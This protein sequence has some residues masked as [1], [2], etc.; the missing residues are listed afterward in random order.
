MKEA[1]LDRLSSRFVFVVGKGGVGKTTAA[2][3]VALASA[4]RGVATLL[5]STDPAH[6]L[7]DLF[8]LDASGGDELESPCTPA[9]HVQ[10]LDARAHVARWMDR[11]REPVRDLFD[12]GTYLEAEDV[13]PFLDLSLPG[14]DEV[15]GILHLADLVAAWP[16]RV[17]V[18]TAPTG[19]ALRLLDA[20]DVVDSWTHAFD[21]MAAKIHAVSTGLIGTSVRVAAEDLVDELATRVDAYRSRVLADA[22]VL[23]VE[24]GGSVV[25]AESRR[26]RTGLIERGFAN[27]VRIGI[28][29]PDDWGDA[30][31]EHMIPFRRDLVGCDGLRRWGEP[32]GDDVFPASASQAGAPVEPWI[33]AQPARLLFFTGKGGVG[34]STCAAAWALALVDRGPVTLVSVDP[35]G[36]LDDVLGGREV[37]GLRVRQ[38]DADQAFGDFKE[39]YR[40]SVADAFDRITGRGGAAL[41]RRVVESL[42]ELAPAGLDEIFAVSAL[43]DET[44]GDGVVIVDTAPTGHFLR[45]LTMPDTGLA[46]TRELMRVLLKYRAVLGLDAF[47]E[48]LLD[49]AKR[50]KRLSLALSDPSRAAAVI[51]RQPGPLVS[52]ESA[53]L[54]TSLEEAAV[55]IAAVIANREPAAEGPPVDSMAPGLPRI[56]APPLAEPPVGPDALRAF[57]ARW[58]VHT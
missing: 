29:G 51:V 14:I 26:L 17:V 43:L 57:R 9:L 49:F 20:D 34:K 58:R 11:A 53:R 38:V 6:S 4:D 28:E 8:G 23:V 36:S 5:L 46:W 10:E 31:P 19:H 1:L 47:A 54:A 25:R 12:R 42:L 32:D 41:D 44:D 16:E 40:E 37:P 55:S 27:V 24:R 2:G 21:A 18:D 48:R 33:A 35:A 39:R 7:G 30:P 22:S 52:A 13:D 50:L 3:A 15:A 45:L 56:V